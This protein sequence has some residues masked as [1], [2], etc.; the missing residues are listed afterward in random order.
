MA[1]TGSNENDVL[2]PVYGVLTL[3]GDLP[4]GTYT[5]TL[6]ITLSW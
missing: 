6:L 5:D 3:P 1:V 2:L 4:A